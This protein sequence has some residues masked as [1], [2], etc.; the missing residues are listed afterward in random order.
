M[1]Y[2]VTQ[3]WQFCIICFHL[4]LYYYY[5]ES[6]FDSQNIPAK[7]EYYFD[8]LNNLKIWRK[9]EFHNFNCLELQMEFDVII[10]WVNLRILLILV[11]KL[12]INS[13]LNNNYRHQSWGIALF[14]Y[15]NM[16]LVNMKLGTILNF[17]LVKL[18]YIWLVL[19]KSI[20]DNFKTLEWTDVLF[21]WVWGRQTEVNIFLKI[22]EDSKFICG[23]VQ[24]VVMCYE[25]VTKFSHL[26]WSWKDYK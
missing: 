17:S 25:F 16:K 2:A 10:F 5:R 1:S 8:E 9:F 18:L 3:A 15:G 14:E 13:F 19:I 22:M 6:Q 21:L 24:S 26:K 11:R 23:Y 20:Q 7:R 12:R 4:N